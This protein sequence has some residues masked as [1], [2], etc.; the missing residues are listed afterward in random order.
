[1][2]HDRT[3]SNEAKSAAKVLHEWC[4]TTSRANVQTVVVKGALDTFS[5]SLSC[6]IVAV[7]CLIVFF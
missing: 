7:G 3:V 1:M 5:S 6:A 4:R 2:Q